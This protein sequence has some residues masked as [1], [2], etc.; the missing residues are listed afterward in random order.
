MY[1]FC[2]SAQLAR[3]LKKTHQKAIQNKLQILE[4][5]NLIAKHYT[6]QYKLAGRAAEYYLTVQGAR[7]LAAQYPDYI[8][9]TALRRVYRN[10][11]VSDSFIRQ[12]ISIAT[13]ALQL[14][15]FLPVKGY[16]R[17]GQPFTRSQMIDPGAFPTW[18]PDL[19]FQIHKTKETK[20]T[21][22][23]DIWRN[24]DSLFLAVRKLKHYLK[25][26]ELEW[27]SE[28]GPPGIIAVCADTHMARKLQ[29]HMKRLLDDCWDEDIVLATI[30]FAQLAT[31]D[32][33][34]TPL[35]SKTNPDEPPTLVSLVD[36]VTNTP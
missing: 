35:W 22:Y 14:Y 16:P 28:I 4:S 34:K 11:T 15:S 21:F 8:T 3:I 5:Q 26:I 25:Y 7:L 36:L 33:P 10:R 12:C 32:S 24:Q 1:R 31:L 18:Q 2:T 19:Y 6:S 23:L 30:T 27:D 20:R 17:W 9:P 13:V 29:R